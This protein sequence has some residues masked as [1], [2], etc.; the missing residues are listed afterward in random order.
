[1]WENILKATATPPKGTS[2]KDIKSLLIS[3]LTN[4][5]NSLEKNLSKL[6]TKIREAEKK[7]SD[8]VSP[9]TQDIRIFEIADEGFRE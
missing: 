5:I 6:I 9:L 8:E 7:I 1:M 3:A 2:V 4:P